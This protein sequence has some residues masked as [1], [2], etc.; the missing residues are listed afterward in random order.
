[1]ERNETEISACGTVPNQTVKNRLP[2][3]S[4]EVRET[5]TSHACLHSQRIN[6]T[7]GLAMSYVS[8]MD[9]CRF[10]TLTMQMENGH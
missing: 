8:R 5:V 4:Q 2:C 7:P 9:L 10:L 6:C 1:M 3:V